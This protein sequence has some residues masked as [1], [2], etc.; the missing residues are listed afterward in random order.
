MR[1][2]LFWAITQQVVVIPYR[3]FGTNIGSTF[4]GQEQKKVGKELPLFA[5]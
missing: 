2:A 1:T 4:N 5:A 3:N